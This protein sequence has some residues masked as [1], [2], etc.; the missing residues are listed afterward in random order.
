MTATYDVEVLR[1]IKR[2][3]LFQLPMIILWALL[4]AYVLGF[5]WYRMIRFGFTLT[6]DSVFEVVGLGM[7]LGSMLQIYTGSRDN[8]HLVKTNLFRLTRHPMYH[9]MFIAACGSFFHADLRDPI[10]WSIFISFTVLI[11]IAGRYQEKETLARWGDEARIYYDNTPRFIFEWPWFWI[12]FL[13][14]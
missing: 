10:F 4:P 14:F 13:P 11:L 6:W 7:M 9:G 5:E 3:T 12:R 1:Y 8:R 2:G